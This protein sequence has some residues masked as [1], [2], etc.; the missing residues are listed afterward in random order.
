MSLLKVLSREHVVL[1]TEHVL[2][3][4]VQSKFVAA[5]QENP[6]GLLVTHLV[7]LIV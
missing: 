5:V 7:E 2:F 3:D 1:S 4:L 6:L